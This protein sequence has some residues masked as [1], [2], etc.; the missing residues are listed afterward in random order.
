VVVEH[1]NVLRLVKNSNYIDMSRGDKLLLTGAFGFDIT[2]FEIWG[3]LLNGVRLFWAHQDTILDEVRLGEILRENKISILHLIPQLFN[4]LADRAPGIFAGPRY[5]LVG[6]DLVSPVYVNKIRNRYPALK[7]LHM[8]GPT[9]NT[10]FSTFFPVEK[11]Y[12][13]T[14]PIGSPIKNSTVYIVNAAGGFQP[15]G[16]VGEIV[17]G[18][19]GI[20][21]GYLNNPGLTAQK[22]INYKLQIPNYKQSTCLKKRQVPY[23]K[24]QITNKVVP[25]GR[26]LNAFGEREAHELRELP[27]IETTFNEKLLRG[28]PDASRGGFLEK[29]PVKHLA[30]RRQ[31]I[32]KT[33]D[34]GRWLADGTIEFL[35]RKDG[36]VKVRGFRIE[37]E[38]IEVC[39]LSHPAIK[40][41]VVLL[42]EKEDRDR[43]LCAY[44]VSGVWFNVTELREYL[45]GRLPDY[46]IPA[47]FF[48]VDRV[49]LTT[50]GKVDRRALA[51][52]AKKLAPGAEYAAPRSDKESL[53]ADIWK[54]VLQV[55]EVGI[56]D[57]FFDLGGT[58]MDIV[59]VH[60]R[61]KEAMD[62]N[63]SIVSLY[64]YTTIDA[65][66]RFM[67]SE[68]AGDHETPG[69]DGEREDMIRR[70]KAEKVRMREKRMRR[71]Q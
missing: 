69:G 22:F 63:I 2:T 43:Y 21:R 46:M 3:S 62:K 58:S 27:P 59:R 67:G 9:E 64:R 14:I 60:S 23:D 56:Y 45:V 49:P 30:R 54:E 28:G 47:D 33:G 10:T 53:M 26:V 4:R 42:T 71:S 35:G 7:I 68:E 24:S 55:E 57:N 6:G 19:E 66:S 18:G 16:V 15:L 8:Y 37:P 25:C 17:V 12:K 51:G 31:R 48:Q 11:D 13:T 41:A 50:N 36:Q 29:S 44:I 5:L 40:Q 39:L 52:L 20:A 61:L 38:E 65:F 70:G 32:Y 1:S 34:L